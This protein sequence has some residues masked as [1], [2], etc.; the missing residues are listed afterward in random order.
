[1]IS[2][3]A[4]ISSIMFITI[5]PFI[6]STCFEVINSLGVPYHDWLDIWE[7]TIVK[8]ESQLRKF[9]HKE[10]HVKMW[11]AEWKCVEL[12]MSHWLNC[13]NG[14][15]RKVIIRPTWFIC[16]NNGFFYNDRLLWL[17]HEIQTLYTYDVFSLRMLRRAITV[18]SSISRPKYALELKNC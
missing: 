8:C 10:I 17:L 15:H 6:F 11:S 16:Q 2:V 13:V 4:I 14:R 18:C 1:M 9:S 7:Q 12:K 3:D 5:L